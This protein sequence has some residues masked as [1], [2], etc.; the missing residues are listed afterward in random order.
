MLKVLI[1]YNSSRISL[2]LNILSTVNE[3]EKCLLNLG[4]HVSRVP[5]SS[6]LEMFARKIKSKRPDVIFNLC[7]AVGRDSTKEKSVAAIYELLRIPFTGNSSLALGICHDKALTKT[8]LKSLHIP[9]PDFKVVKD[10]NN[11][12]TTFEFPAIVKPLH[13]D[14]SCGITAHSF[15][16]NQLMLER[17]VK[18][19]LHRFKQPALVE[20][21]I[22]GKELQVSIL[23][24]KNPEV[25]AI[26]EMSYAG[27]PKKLPKIVTYSAKWHPTSVYYKHTNPLI[28]ARINPNVEKKIIAMSKK[29][30]EEFNLRG[31]ARIDF[32]LSRDKP[33]VIDINPNPDISSDAGFAKAGAYAGFTYQQIIGKIVALALE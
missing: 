4:Y 1:V 12:F 29:I 2:D 31:Y 20:K 8:I 22:G 32:R 21:F 19:I 3:V 10:T 33:H 27:L 6:N 24:N 26:A 18:Y 28:P 14:G 16:K 9:T 7:E 11:D 30:F 25:L 23:G 13:E 17:R 15:I 5:I